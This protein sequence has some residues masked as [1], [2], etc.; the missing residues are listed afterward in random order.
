M[1]AGGPPDDR[2]SVWI[3]MIACGTCSHP[4]DGSFDVI[5][6]SRKR[7]FCFAVFF[8]AGKPVVYCCS[9]VS[10]FSSRFYI[11]QAL[12]TTAAIISPSSPKD[13]DNCGERPTTLTWLCYVELEIYVSASAESYTVFN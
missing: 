5:Y 13:V 10:L 1:T 3:D 11:E 7:I 6:L 12:L 2:D 4:A 8:Y 9:H